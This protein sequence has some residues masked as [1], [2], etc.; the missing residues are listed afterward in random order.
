[1]PSDHSSIAA[2]HRARTLSR[3]KSLRKHERWLVQQH[4]RHQSQPNLHATDS[5]K[6]YFGESL[7]RRATSFRTQRSRGT[8]TSDAPGFERLVSPFTSS[9]ALINSV[10]PNTPP[11]GLSSHAESGFPWNEVNWNRSRRKLG[12][13]SSIRH[14]LTPYPATTT[15]QVSKA[16]A[17]R[18]NNFSAGELD[19]VSHLRQTVR[20]AHAP[21]PAAT[22][23][24][25]VVTAPQHHVNQSFAHP[26][27]ASR[28]STSTLTTTDS[29]SNTTSSSQVSSDSDTLMHLYAASATMH[30]RLRPNSL[31]RAQ[32]Y[33]HPS[34]N[35]RRS[36]LGR[37]ETSSSSPPHTHLRTEPKGKDRHKSPQRHQRHRH[38]R[39]VYPLAPG[40]DHDGSSTLFQARALVHKCS[41]E[42]VYAL[43]APTSGKPQTQLQQPHPQGKTIWSQTRLIV[44][45]LIVSL[46]YLPA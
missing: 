43:G 35:P 19:A 18:V 33:A 12:L 22:Q 9:T 38:P 14:L 8:S 11:T 30:A 10:Y 39:L 34:R 20:R 1:M 29:D 5:N 36:E 26:R 37:S 44:N 23:D 42:L 46:N 17:E 4:D 45:N 24:T 3:A 25:A 31:L 16:T 6:Q 27:T 32:T 13:S 40:H 15:R 2:R 7:L 28:D 41:A 21:L